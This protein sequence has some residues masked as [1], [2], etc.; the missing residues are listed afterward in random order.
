MQT[1]K[2]SVFTRSWRKGDTHCGAR[3]NGTLC[4][5]PESTQ[6]QE[7][8]LCRLWTS[9]SVVHPR[10]HG[11]CWC[12]G[13]RVPMAPR[14]HEKSLQW[15]WDH[16]AKSLSSQ[17]LWCKPIRLCSGNGGRREEPKVSKGDR[18]R[19]LEAN[20]AYIRC[21][22]KTNKPNKCMLIMII[23]K[24]GTNWSHIANAKD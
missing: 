16:Q 19:E 5:K 17:V 18:H 13:V 15:T 10:P 14:A 1:V 8:A 12:W 11:W 21:L 22:L 24:Q 2:I 20:Q 3:D 4:M 6:Q 23:K 7:N 9:I